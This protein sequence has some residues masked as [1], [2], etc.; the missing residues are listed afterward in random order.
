[1]K[2]ANTRILTFAMIAFIFIA[3]TSEKTKL[4]NAI[5]ADEEILRSDSNGTMNKEVLTRTMHNYLEYATKFPDDTISPEY[6]VRAADLSNG[7][8][9]YQQ[10]IDLFRKVYTTY[11]EHRKAAAAMFMEG[12]VFE[13]SMHQKDSAKAIYSEFIRRYP[14]HVLAASAKASLDQLNNNLSD[15]ELIRMFEARA[16][17]ANKKSN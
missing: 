4:A 10:S 13:T 5:K 9:Q 12:F 16:D 17:S 7:I 15:E 2:Q 11:P 1:M 14:D 8:R 3:C 6:L